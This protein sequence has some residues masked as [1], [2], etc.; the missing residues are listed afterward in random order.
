V[1]DTVTG[2]TWQRNLPEMY[3]GCG[4]AG[5]TWAAAKLYCDTLMLEAGGWRAPTLIEL[6]SILDDDRVMPA[7]DLGAFP[8]TPATTFWSASTR[9]SSQNEA[10]MVS[11]ADYQTTSSAKTGSARVRCVR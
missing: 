5:C 8:N 1:L 7:I 4:A 2:L 11:F 9:F 10:W 6:V 3:A